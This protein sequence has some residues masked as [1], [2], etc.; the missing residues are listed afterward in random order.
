MKE[1]PDAT[2]Y[3]QGVVAWAFGI[4]MAFLLVYVTYGADAVHLIVSAEEPWPV[5]IVFLVTYFGIQ[6]VP[7]KH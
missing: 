3:I 7:W 4:I 1:K 2:A 5:F 6:T